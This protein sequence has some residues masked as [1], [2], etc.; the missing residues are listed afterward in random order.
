[1]RTNIV[2]DDQ[3]V[4]QGLKL[5][6]VRTKRDLVNLALAEMVRQLKRKALLQHR[7]KVKWEGSLNEMRKLR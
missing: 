2:L 7:G 1:M 5:T 3:L 4:E 6:N